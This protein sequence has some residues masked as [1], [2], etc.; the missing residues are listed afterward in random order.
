ME[1]L[2]YAEKGIGVLFALCFSYQLYYLVRVL[3]MKKREKKMDCP[4]H[5]IAVVISARN[6]ETV[7]GPLIESI[8][9][10]NYPDGYFRVYVVADNCTDHTAMVARSRGATVFERFDKNRLGKGYALDYL[11]N[12]I[13][14]MNGKEE[15]YLVLDADNILDRNYLKEMNRV[16][17]SGYRIV[18]GYRNSKNYGSNWISAGYSL[19][20]LREAK[21]LNQARM[22]LGTSCSVSGTGFMVS[23]ELI[24]KQ[25]GWKHFLLTEDM[26]FSVDWILKGEKIGYCADAILYDEQPVSWSQSW[27]QRLRWTKGFYQVFGKYGSAL[28]KNAVV[29]HDFS[30]FDML[31]I[32]SPA[33]ILTCLSVLCHSVQLGYAFIAAAPESLIFETTRNIF[34]AIANG[35]AAMFL[36]ALITTLSEWNRICSAPGKKIKYLF[37]FPLFMLTYVPIAITALFKKVEWKPIRHT[38]HKSCDQIRAEIRS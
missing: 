3:F 8:N 22:S 11:F 7:I 20:F 15:A 6:E 23:R 28:A 4:A 34:I 35:Y 32:L 25:G 10:Q 9:S 12:R 26:E 30:S 16:F 29:R 33:A 36:L 17:D 27:H 21:F 19:W 38:V 2:T 31:M 5:R 13:R 18:T 37:T 24:E 14:S 1:F